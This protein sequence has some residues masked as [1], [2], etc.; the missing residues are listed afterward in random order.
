MTVLGLATAAGVPGLALCTGREEPLNWRGAPRQDLRG[1][2]AAAGDLLQKA[3]V[4]ASELDVVACGRGP[5]AFTGVR[6]GIALAQGFALGAG[7]PVVAVS[8]LRALA[9]KA[10]REHGWEQVLAM[11][12]ARKGEIYQAAY[13]C[14]QST[15]REVGAECLVKPESVCVPGGKWA[16]AGP[17][18]ALVDAQHHAVDSA[19]VPDAEAVAKL[20]RHDF[21]VN[22]GIS[23]LA[24]EPVYLRDRVVAGSRRLRQ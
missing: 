14:S 23:P 24:V 22:G 18:A 19:L 16:L 5:G 9:F 4:E 8:D 13:D 2:L 20:A 1:I 12:D 7:C 10:S 11:L 3:G 21:A 17:G 15:P 6:L